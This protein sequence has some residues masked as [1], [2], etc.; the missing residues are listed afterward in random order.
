MLKLTSKIFCRDIEEI[1]N[2][3]NYWFKDVEFFMDTSYFAI[4]DWSEYKKES[5]EKYVIININSKW[6]LFMDDLIK[7][8]QKYINLG[9]MVYFIPVCAGL[10]DDD[11]R[12]FLKIKDIINN[13]KFVA[14]DRTQDFE[15]FL[16]LLWWAE[17]VISARLHLFLIS[18]FIWLDTKVYPYQKKINKMKKVIDELIK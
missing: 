18:E 10:T 9:Y 6:K 11:A 1:E 12:Y 14:Y 15:K 16:K 5:K 3:K 4:D 13:E 2:I 17:K 8:S 7:E